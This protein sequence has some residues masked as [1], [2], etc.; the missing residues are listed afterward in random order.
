MFHM[1]YQAFS[2]K[3]KKMKIKVSSAAF[4]LCAFKTN[5]I[6]QIGSNET[7]FSFFPWKINLLTAQFYLLKVD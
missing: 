5:I 1:K 6:C 2:L 4:V 7:P 3:N